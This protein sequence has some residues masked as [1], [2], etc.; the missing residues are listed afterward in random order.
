[1]A[2]RLSLPYDYKLVFLV[3][4]ALQ[5]S[6]G[7]A[8]LSRAHQ[9]SRWVVGQKSWSSSCRA[10]GSL[11]HVLPVVNDKKRGQAK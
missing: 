2:T 9:G 8:H 6:R 1:M 7:S 3:L 4:T 11:T 5:A 10:S